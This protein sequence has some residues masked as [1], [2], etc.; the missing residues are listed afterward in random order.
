MTHK[1]LESEAFAAADRLKSALR[2][3][4]QP[5]FERLPHAPQQ[6]AA[7]SLERMSAERPG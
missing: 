6:T 7:R 4:S 2:A 3:A 5:V 1:L